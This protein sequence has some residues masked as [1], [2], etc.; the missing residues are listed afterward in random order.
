MARIAGVDIPRDKRVEVALTYIYGIGPTSSQKILA[1]TGVLASMLV[2]AGGLCY[3][4]GA[5]VYAI[6]KPDPFPAFFGYHEV[7]HALVIA[8]VAFQY[9]SVVFFVLPR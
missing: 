8:A 5:V 3:T 1:R 4:A 9:V 7:F 6:R 2:L